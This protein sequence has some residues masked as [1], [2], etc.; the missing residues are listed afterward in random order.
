MVTDTDYSTDRQT[1]AMI[2]RLPVY[3]GTSLVDQESG[4]IFYAGRFLPRDATLVRYVL[5][6][7]L[8]QPMDD[9]SP[10][11]RTLSRFD[12]LVMLSS[13]PS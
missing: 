1:W 3:L 9:K 2:M 5:R 8:T 4:R 7:C 6:L 10:V 12:G 11:K 13:Q